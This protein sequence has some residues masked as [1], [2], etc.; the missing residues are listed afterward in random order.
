VRP[1]RDGH[2]VR[3]A[4]RRQRA[5]RLPCY[6]CGQ[7]IDYDADQYDPRSF[8][9]DHLVPLS[10]APELAMDP[11]N[12]RSSCRRCNRAKSDGPVNGAKQAPTSRRWL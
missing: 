7:P 3:E 10:V 1:G 6:L 12:H 2:R 11:S 4:R 8:Q 9:L 5:K